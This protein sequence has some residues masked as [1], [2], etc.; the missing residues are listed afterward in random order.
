MKENGRA[1]QSTSSVVFFGYSDAP[2]FALLLFRSFDVAFPRFRTLGTTSFDVIGVKSVDC[3]NIGS[4][5]SIGACVTSFIDSS[6]SP[7]RENQ[8]LLVDVLEKIF[9]C[10]IPLLKSLITLLKEKVQFSTR[11]I[12]CLY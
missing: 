3:F 12:S 1:N 8:R 6:P 2:T 10:L 5:A 9:A 4:L 7:A 11:L